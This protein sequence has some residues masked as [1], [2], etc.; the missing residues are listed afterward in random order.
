MQIDPKM[1]QTLSL[2]SVDQVGIVVRDMETT[3]KN[4]EEILGI[5]FPKVFVPD[6]FNRIYRG[7]PGNFR[8]K[9]AHSMMGELQVE[10]IQ[11]LEGD[12]PY[13]EFLEKWGEGIHHLG[14]V[15]NNLEERVEAFQKLGVGVL[16]RGERVGSK[17]AYMDTERLFGVII[18]F[19]QRDS[20]R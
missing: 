7:K 14:F 11:C 2:Q 12:T 20:K 17:F 19:M 15:V 1:K 18:E 13:T 3:M 4:Y 5:K 9:I 10:L 6:F 16:M 8:M